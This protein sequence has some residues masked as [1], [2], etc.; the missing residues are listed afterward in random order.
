MPTHIDT[1]I[2]TAL[3]AAA[4]AKGSEPDKHTV[5]MP[6]GVPGYTLHD[7]AREVP[8]SEPPVLPI[9]LATPPIC[10]WC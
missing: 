7:E 1:A 9:N 8:L 3:Q 6:I 4:V 2:D 10:G 5:M